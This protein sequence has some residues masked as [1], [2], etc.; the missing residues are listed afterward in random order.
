MKL[1]LHIDTNKKTGTYRIVK[2]I[3][4]DGIVQLITGLDKADLDGIRSMINE[5]IGEIT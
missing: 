3:G 1:S 2:E 5:T 4:R